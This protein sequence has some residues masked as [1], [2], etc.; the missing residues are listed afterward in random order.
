LAP[1]LLGKLVVTADGRAGRIVEVE[2]YRGE[3][4]PAS[5]AFRGRTARN[6][7][8][9]GAPGLLYVYF[10]YG[11][12]Y[13]ANVV[14]GSV[15]EAQAVLLRALE[16]VAG[17]EAMRLA[18]P[19]SDRDLCRGPARLCRAL[20]IDTGFDGVDLTTGGGGIW[21]ADDGAAA[22]DAPA[23][24]GR[25]GLSKASEFPWRFSIPDHQGVSGPIRARGKISPQG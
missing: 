16:P 2:A 12:H 11:M 3:Q 8:M 10:T 14:A 21:L 13:C 9:F 1:E 18:R 4:D 6:S 23:V 25:I 20:G 17:L 7:T 24:S 5:H 22:P 19:V 15:G